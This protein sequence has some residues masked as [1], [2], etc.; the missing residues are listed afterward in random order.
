MYIKDRK[1]RFIFKDFFS[2]LKYTQ[3]FCEHFDLCGGCIFQNMEY[4]SQLELKKLMLKRCLKK[5]E[6]DISLNN[7]FPADE[8]KF[9]RNRMD[10]AVSEQD[11]QN[12]VI[13]LREYGKWW[14]T[15][16]IRVCWIFS[17]KV[18]VILD[19]VREFLKNTGLRGYDPV[20]GKGDVRYIVLREGKNSGKFLVAIVASHEKFPFADFC[21][22]FPIR[23]S[24]FAFAVSSS[25]ANLST[26]EV[27]EFRGETF[28]EKI[29]GFE[30]LI[31][32]F[33]FFQTNTHM[34]EKLV[35]KIS[36]YINSLD[37][38]E[39]MADL[40]SGVGLFSIIFAKKFDRVYGIEVDFDAVYFAEQNSILNAVKNTIFVSGR[41]ED[42]IRKISTDI[43]LVDPPRSGLGRSVCK[44][45]L[46]MKR[47]KK[48][49]YVS[50]NAESFSR[51]MKLLREKFD[52]EGLY[53]FDFF[54][55][56]KHF[57]ILCFMSRK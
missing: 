6:L 26:G 10:Y 39:V 9:Y 43:I 31:P 21:D 4:E 32:T 13:G 20:S 52:V 11:G 40:Y 23:N 29:C 5:Y 34:A 47:L 46:D 24:S 50:C 28:S 54:P 16:D 51:D 30:F 37:K 41:V 18:P 33:S 27:L 36:E 3:Y 57:E 19:Y 2:S 1:I 44:G 7:F 49:I 8:T 22:N 48:L 45:I 55:H 38:L 17:D 35:L 53:A 56:T 14:R 42:N 15:V 25:R 12:I